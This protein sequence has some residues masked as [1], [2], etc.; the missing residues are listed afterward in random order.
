MAQFEFTTN[1]S[2]SPGG[3]YDFLLKPAN[4]QRI[5][6]PAIGLTFTKAPEVV[7]EGA[8]IE[9]EMSGLGKVQRAVH[10]II[11]L[12]TNTRIV[13]LQ[14]E[15]ALRSWKHEHHFEASG[16][17]VVM[18][19]LILFDPPGGILGFI[20]TEDRILSQLDDGFFYR[21]QQLERIVDSGEIS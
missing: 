3:L 13:E 1:L 16:D 11:E 8:R 6:S 20:A 2:C 10:E 7:T 14:V 12:I 21:Q 15:G 17:G 19:D 4:V 5:S 9:F 18:Q